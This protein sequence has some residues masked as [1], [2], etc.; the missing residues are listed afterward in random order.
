MTEATDS[1]SNLM[2]YWRTDLG[3]GITFLQYHLLRWVKSPVSK[4]ISVPADPTM[5]ACVEYRYTPFCVQTQVGCLKH[6]LAVW[7]HLHWYFV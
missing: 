7:T 3:A 2:F 5:F 1:K 6:L 4:H